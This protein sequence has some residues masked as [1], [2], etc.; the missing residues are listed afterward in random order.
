MFTDTCGMWSV[1]GWSVVIKF[2]YYL[3]DSMVEWP[4]HWLDIFTVKLEGVA[5]DITW[6]KV[7]IYGT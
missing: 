3:W 4:L 1:D 2:L 7:I 5:K 6:K